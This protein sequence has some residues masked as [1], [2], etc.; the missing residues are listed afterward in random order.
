MYDR[1]LT[2][3]QTLQHEIQ[4]RLLKFNETNQR[5]IVIMCFGAWYIP[6]NFD[7]F[8]NDVTRFVNYWNKVQP[9]NSALIWRDV[10]PQHFKNKDETGVYDPSLHTETVIGGPYNCHKSKTL[11]AQK[12][13]LKP[14]R[15]V[16]S[17]AN[18]IY[19]LPVFDWAQSMHYG[20]NIRSGDCTHYCIPIMAA[21][22]TLL[23]KLTFLTDNQ[24]K[25]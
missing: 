16:V 11:C 20:H 23:L 6:N 8:H 25:K 2:S 24:I 21:W 9:V 13:F 18:K 5:L 1:V 15:D 7:R 4:S 17:S 3:E 10:L 12:L 22:N 14:T 19:S